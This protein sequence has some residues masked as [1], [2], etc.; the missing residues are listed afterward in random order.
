MRNRSGSLDWG[1]T[2]L[3]FLNQLISRVP[4]NNILIGYQI[5]SFATVEFF[6]SPLPL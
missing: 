5:S 3:R 4:F 1:I 6:D 2:P